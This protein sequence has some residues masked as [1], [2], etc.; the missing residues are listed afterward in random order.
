MIKTLMKSIR[1]YRKESILSPIFV[2]VEVFIEMFIPY[3][4]A[5]LIDDGIM[6]GNTSLITKL[7]LFIII[8]GFYLFN[9]WYWC[10]LLLS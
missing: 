10:K 8:N 6:K 2:T 4:M 3:V 5:W 9:V 7:G 1:Q